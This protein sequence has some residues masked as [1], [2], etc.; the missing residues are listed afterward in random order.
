[1]TTR[2]ALV[3]CFAALAACSGD[4]GPAGPPG[5]DGTNG[6]NGSNGSDGNDII[7]SA[8]AKHGLDIAPVA[9]SLTGLSGPQIELIG[10]GSYLVNAV[11]DCSGCHNS[12][13][14]GYL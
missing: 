4:T 2:N 12:P 11:I 10:Q 6:S 7:L 5:A 13:T 14:G 1:M 9:L 8:R 3:I